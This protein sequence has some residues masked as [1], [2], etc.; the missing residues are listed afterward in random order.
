MIMKT[1]KYL[2]QFSLLNLMIFHGVLA[3]S[4][5]KPIPQKSGIDGFILVGASVTSYSSNIVAGNSLA[6]VNHS[7]TNGL[8]Y[9]PSAEKGSSGIFTGELNYTFSST[10]TQLY[11]GN[12]LEDVVRYDLTSHLGVRQNI[13]SGGIAS[14]AYITS[15]FLPTYVYEDPFNTEKTNATDRDMQ[16]IQ[17]GWDNI[18][19]NRFN[20]EVS[21]QKFEI[22]NEKSGESLLESDDISQQEQKLLLR[23]GESKKLKVSYFWSINALHHV[24][25]ELVYEKINKD[26]D[27]ISND[28]YGAAVSYF[29]KQKRF[30]FVSK[31]TFSHAEY[32]E[33][34]PI[35]G[36][37]DIGDSNMFG[38]SAVGSYERPF[39]W[40]SVSFIGTVAYCN[41]N[42]NI[43]FYDADILTASIGL[44]YQF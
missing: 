32:K 18:L 21:L 19:N 9:S 4:I 22:D 25:P 30:A 23:N 11:I 41:A 36:K 33:V 16:G 20:I 44:L 43:D 1:Y 42:S 2:I 10:G 35:W 29:Y 5:L 40:E 7:S 6:N 15:G 3:A 13:E 34:N 31:I 14:I 17:L 12:E 28:R 39:S 38:A 26:G 8:D 27:A 24:E 37:S